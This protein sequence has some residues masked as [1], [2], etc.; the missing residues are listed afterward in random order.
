MLLI[1][2]EDIRDTKEVLKMAITRFRRLRELDPF[3]SFFDLPDVFSD[4]MLD[5]PRLV[6]RSRTGD[7]PTAWHPSVDVYDDEEKVYVKMDLPGVSKDDIDI[8]FD[9]H[10]LSITGHRKTEKEVNEDG[11]W[12]RER[13]TGEFRRHVHIPTDVGSDDLKATYKDG[14][15]LVTLHKTEKVKKKKIDIESGAKK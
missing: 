11:Y 14:V 5:F 7:M 15:L 6:G 12:S 4:R 10:I 2:A 8:S 3:T 1:R 9:G 13:Y